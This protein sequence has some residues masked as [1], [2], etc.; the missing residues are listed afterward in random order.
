MNMALSVYEMTTRIYVDCKRKVFCRTA[1]PLSKPTHYPIQASERA[2]GELRLSLL[3][4][5]YTEATR[6]AFELICSKS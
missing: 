6:P 5:G 2:L 3:S 1:V 4:K